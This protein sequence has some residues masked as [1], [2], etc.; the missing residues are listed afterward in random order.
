MSDVNATADGKIV[1]VTIAAAIQTTMTAFLGWPSAETLATQPEKG[2]TPS[3][4]TANTRRDAATMAIA[5]FC[6]VVLKSIREIS[7]A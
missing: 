1:H 7:A 4:A 2:R 3:L 6:T 5:V